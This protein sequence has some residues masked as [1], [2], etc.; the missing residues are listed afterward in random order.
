VQLAQVLSAA[1]L[2][3]PLAGPL[4]LV[5][6]ESGQRL[7]LVIDAAMLADYRARLRR[8]LDEVAAACALAG[9]AHALVS[10]DHSLESVV[11]PLLHRRTLQR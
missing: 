8:R 9:A 2:E 5:D 1:E 6:C 4:A 7:E 10:A 11:L 3:P